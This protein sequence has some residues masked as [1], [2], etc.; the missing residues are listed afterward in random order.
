MNRAA[1]SSQNTFFAE[2]S[3]EHALCAQTHVFCDFVAVF[4]S[5]TRASRAL[6]LSVAMSEHQVT[7]QTRAAPAP[8][9]T[10]ALRCPRPPRTLVCGGGAACCVASS[11]SRHGQPGQRRRRC[12][13][14]RGRSQSAWPGLRSTSRRALFR[15]QK[16]TCSSLRC[17]SSSASNSCAPVVQAATPVTLRVQV[18][19]SWHLALPRRPHSAWA[20]VR[21]HAQRR[22]RQRRASRRHQ[23]RHVR[24]IHAQR[25]AA[26]P[27]TQVR[28]GAKVLP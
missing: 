27:P 10:L 2:S 16:T 25:R 14:A 15:H 19:R 13:A 20:S 6:A 18:R 12:P 1:L 23:C 28:S 5:V 3:F 8:L 7:P 11:W 4:I 21:R 22:H 17:A 9:G 24:R 26:R